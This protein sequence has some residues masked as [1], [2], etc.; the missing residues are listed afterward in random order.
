MYIYLQNYLIFVCFFC[1]LVFNKCGAINDGSNASSATTNCNNES[2]RDVIEHSTSTSE[3]NTLVLQV[4]EELNQP[5][6]FMDMLNEENE[7]TFVELFK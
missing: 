4:A 1:S 3:S 5:F 6:S 2:S 7:G